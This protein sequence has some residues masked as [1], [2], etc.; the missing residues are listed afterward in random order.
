M[1]NGF[2]RG[3]WN[4][5]GRYFMVRLLDAHSWVEAHLDGAGWV[6]LDPSPRGEAAADFFTQRDTILWQ[7]HDAE[8]PFQSC[9]RMLGGGR[10][11]LEHVVPLFTADDDRVPAVGGFARRPLFA[12]ELW[13]ARLGRY[14]PGDM[15]YLPRFSSLLY[16]KH[17][18]PFAARAPEVWDY[19]YGN[20]AAARMRTVALQA[21]L[22]HGVDLRPILAE[23]RQ[24]VLLVCGE[25]VNLVRGDAYHESEEFVLVERGDEVNWTVPYKVVKLAPDAPPEIRTG[26]HPQ[27]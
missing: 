8:H 15:R 20:A 5:Y 4:P 18:A 1:V 14:L 2:Q 25:T 3:E 17:H 9:E 22:L 11:A 24:P 7:G 19:F 26:P 23:V 13:L 12:W 21:L 16:R 10:A 27:R 6:T